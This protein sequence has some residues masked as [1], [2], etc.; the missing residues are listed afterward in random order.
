MPGRIASQ[1]FL[2]LLP[3]FHSLT[4]QSTGDQA[5][6]I[7]QYLFSNDLDVPVGH[8]VHTGMLNERGGY[9]NDCCIARLSKRR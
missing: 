7:L 9:E 3:L 5:L 8:I 6:E 4:L 1:R 2:H